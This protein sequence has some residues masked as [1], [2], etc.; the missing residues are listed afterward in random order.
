MLLQAARQR[1]LTPG[2][3]L[4]EDEAQRI[5][6]ILTAM[7]AIGGGSTGNLA[8]AKAAATTA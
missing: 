8:A 4:T 6:Q 3:R 7:P 2:G 1:L 5:Q